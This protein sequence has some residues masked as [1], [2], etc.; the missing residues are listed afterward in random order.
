MCIELQ[1]KAIKYYDK[2]Y[3]Q[4]KRVNELGRKVKFEKAK[5]AYKQNDRLVAKYVKN[6][7]RDTGINWDK[8]KKYGKKLESSNERLTKRTEEYLST[9]KKN[10]V[11]SL[12][13]KDVEHG[14]RYVDARL[15]EPNLTYEKDVRVSDDF[16]KRY[17]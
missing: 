14:Y 9:L 16:A 6:T 15:F 10:K 5:Q 3:D 17:E 1:K 4:V 8:A 7:A 13:K 2:S 12:L 11:K